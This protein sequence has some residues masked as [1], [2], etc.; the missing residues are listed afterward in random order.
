MGET[1]ESPLPRAAA[2]SDN[3]R[4]VRYLLLAS[5][6]ALIAQVAITDYGTGTSGVAALWLVIGCV[7]LWLVY[8]KH[9]RVARG[10]IVVT[11]MVGAAIYGLG[12][13][14]DVTAAALVLAHVGQAA[15][16]LLGPVRHHVSPA[17]R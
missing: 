4:T 3:L 11:S 8:S 14:S 6:A 15:P 7:L 9:S 16:L 5:A 1:V 2:R 13:F 10:F 12:A 17:S